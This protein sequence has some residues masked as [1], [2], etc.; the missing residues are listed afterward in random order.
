MLTKLTDT[1]SY[2]EPDFFYLVEAFG[3]TKDDKELQKTILKVYEFLDS[4]PFPDDFIDSKLSMFTAFSKASDS[5]WGKI[6]FAY[7]NEAVTFMRALIK[8]YMARCTIV[9]KDLE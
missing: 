4:H 5:V 7:A 1:K 6:L 2:G 8:S 3:G 9:R